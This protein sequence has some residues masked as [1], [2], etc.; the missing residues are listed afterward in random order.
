MEETLLRRPCNPMPLLAFVNDREIES[1]DTF[2]V[3]V[4]LED[5]AWATSITGKI[6]DFL[7]LGQED[8][9][10]V[11]TGLESCEAGLGSE[12]MSFGGKTG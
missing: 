11:E 7:N 8:H 2:K 10:M 1:R 9:A 12:C 3:L 5:N 4:L 6:V